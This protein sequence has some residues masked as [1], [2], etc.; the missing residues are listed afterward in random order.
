[1]ATSA[2]SGVPARAHDHRRCTFTPGGVDRLPLSSHS[3]PG[4]AQHRSDRAI[5]LGGPAAG[6]TRACGGY[7]AR[8]RLSFH[9]SRAAER[10]QGGADGAML[11]LILFAVPCLV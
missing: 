9:R 3:D 5:A 6:T 2:P 7:P 8:R 1:M 10:L 11:P 4:A